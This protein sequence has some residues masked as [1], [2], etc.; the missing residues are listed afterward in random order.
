MKQI[1]FL[2]ILLLLANCCFSQNALEVFR[3]KTADNTRESFL[4]TANHEAKIITENFTYQGMVENIADTFLIID[5]Q[6]VSFRLIRSIA[7]QKADASYVK[8][9]MVGL[10]ITLPAAAFAGLFAYSVAT[11]QKSTAQ[12]CFGGIGSLI[13]IPAAIIWGIPKLFSNKTTF[14]ISEKKWQLNV[15]KK[16]DSKSSR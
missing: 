8:Q 5:S 2:I 9:K 7:F 13:F 10:A 16:Q 3:I 1:S 4:F 6:K 12:S 14:D 11:N 15:L